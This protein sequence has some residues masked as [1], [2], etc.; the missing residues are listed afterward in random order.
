MNTD[1][2]TLKFVDSKTSINYSDHTW[3]LIV[4]DILICGYTETGNLCTFTSQE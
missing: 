3:T 2:K 4:G 1:I